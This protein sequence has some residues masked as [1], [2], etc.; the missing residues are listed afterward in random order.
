MYKVLT[1]SVSGICMTSS[2]DSRKRKADHSE[3]DDLS[4]EDV[5]RKTKWQLSYKSQS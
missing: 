3:S 1:L 5:P 4:G 2:R